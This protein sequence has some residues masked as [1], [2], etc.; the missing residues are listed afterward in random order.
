MP[1]AN[2]AQRILLMWSLQMKFLSCSCYTECPEMFRP[3][4]RIG[5]ENES[6]KAST[7]GEI[8]VPRVCRGV[9]SSS[10]AP[11]TNTPGSSTAK[12]K[13]RLGR[14]GFTQKQGFR[15]IST[16]LDKILHTH[17]KENT[18]GR[19][20]PRSAHGRLQAK[21]KCFFFYNRLLVTHPKSYTET[22]DRRNFG[23]PPSKWR[24]G[25]VLSIL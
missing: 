4:W 10:S 20:R 22:T 24:W 1:P 15:Q 12:P 16:D 5:A 21:P 9:V 11:A 2:S 14:A 17:C 18:C 6:T 23:G 3:R 8:G 13:H 25:R 7:E 19:L